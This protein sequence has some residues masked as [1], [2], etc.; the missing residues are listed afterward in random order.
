[1]QRHDNI[2]CKFCEWQTAKWGKRSNP[3]LAFRRLYLHMIDCHITEAVG[4]YGEDLDPA[5]TKDEY[6]PVD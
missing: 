3:S 6:F 1:M 2:K 5:E 4:I